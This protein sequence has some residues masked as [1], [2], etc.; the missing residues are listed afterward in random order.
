MSL[1]KQLQIFLLIIFM[2][3]FSVNFII[4]INDTQRYLRTASYSKA[5]DTATALALALGPLMKEAHDP[6]IKSIIRAVADRSFFEEIR[7]D[8]IAVEFSAVEILAQIEGADNWKIVDVSV[9]PKMGEI[10]TNRDQSDFASQL[11]ALEQDQQSQTVSQEVTWIHFL[12]A[13]DFKTGNNVEMTVLIANGDMQRE[14]TLTLTIDTILTQELRASRFDQ[15]PSWF[16]SAFPIELEPA[17]VEISDGWKAVATLS[18]QANPAEAYHRLYQH[19]TQAGVYSL[20]ALIISMLVLSLFL[21]WVLEPLKRIKSL[22]GQIAKGDFDKIESIPKTIELKSV[23]IAMNDMS[24]KLSHFVSKLNGDIDRINQQLNTD[25]LTNL[26]L[27]PVFDNKFKNSL[28]T[29]QQGY[30]FVIKINDLKHIATNND[31]G[32]VDEFIYQFAA[33]LNTTIKQPQLSECES[34]PY[35]FIGAEFALLIKN[36]S[37]E[38]AT[39]LTKLLTAAYSELARQYNYTDITHIG[40]CAFN[41]LSDL[42]TVID[43]AY[44]ALESA[45]QIGPNQGLVFKKSD[46]GR[47]LQQWRELVEQSVNNASFSLDYINPCF[48]LNL[49]QEFNG[50]NQSWVM[51]EAF[52]KVFDEKNIAVPI[53]TFISIAEKYQYIAM[54]DQQVITKVIADMK[55]QQWNHQVL[56]NL[57]LSSLSNIKFIDWLGIQLTKNRRIASQLLFSLSAYAVADNIELFKQFSQK[58]HQFGGQIIIKRYD[59]QLLPLSLIQTIKVDAIRLALEH[60]Q[61]I[62]N[63]VAKQQFV[64]KIQEFSKLLNIKLYTENVTTEQDLMMLH[65][66][67]LYAVSS[68]QA[69]TEV[70]LDE[71]D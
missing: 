25:S 12:P 49:N 57:S 21:R 71:D 59:A 33:T 28:Q 11:A 6:K 3:I 41:Q 48:K 27:K 39:T 8:S 13:T 65:K 14:A 16:V 47:D 64:E 9:A 24:N 60:T 5:Q 37:F 15:T 55:E 63:D 17:R 26:A 7:L 30:I 44:E 19:A 66:L 45:K 58:I 35:R 22:A 56:I 18:V 32:F 51:V 62:A 69:N 23:T 4:S 52:T 70:S 42:D 61:D 54:F 50:M 2:L 67:G 68:D 31:K 38:N 53:A 40:A 34:T 46:Q 20:V 10:S 29:D 36:A 1:S 43:S